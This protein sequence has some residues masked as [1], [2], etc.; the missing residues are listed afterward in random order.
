LLNKEKKRVLIIHVREKQTNKL[1]DTIC[2]KKMFNLLQGIVI[3][4]AP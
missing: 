1:I 3:Y 4:G 2:S